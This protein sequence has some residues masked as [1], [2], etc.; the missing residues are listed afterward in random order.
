MLFFQLFY[1]ESLLSVIGAAWEQIINLECC[2]TVLPNTDHVPISGEGKKKWRTMKEI[3]ISF[4][5]GTNFFSAHLWILGESLRVISPRL[6]TKNSMHES[7]KSYYEISFQIYTL[8]IA[9]NA[10]LR[11][12]ESILLFYC[13]VFPNLKLVCKLHS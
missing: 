13:S 4:I 7:Q 6:R 10:G 12:N 1:K 3:C 8:G 2:S 9:L 11:K 5:T